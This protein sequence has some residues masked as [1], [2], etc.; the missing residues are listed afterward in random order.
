MTKTLINIRFNRKKKLDKNGLA[1]IQIELRLNGKRKFVDTQ[2]KG[3]PENWD[4]SK[5]RFKT[6]H[7][8]SI[9]L[10]QRLNQILEPV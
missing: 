8:N 6:S 2:I 3:K 4:I 10:N 7:T 1:S 5:N 9:K